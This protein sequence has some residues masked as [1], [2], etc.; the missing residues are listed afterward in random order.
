MD[1]P[2]GSAKSQRAP[3]SGPKEKTAPFA[4]QARA[5]SRAFRRSLQPS[6][7]TKRNEDYF[8]ALASAGALGIGALCLAL[9]LLFFDIVSVDALAGAAVAPALETG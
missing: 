4:H 6:A 1:E 2:N 7:P 8:G 5:R 9:A 3:I